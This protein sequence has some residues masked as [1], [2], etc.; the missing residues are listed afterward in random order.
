IRPALLAPLLERNALWL[1]D[2][3]LSN[4]NHRSAR[5]VEQAV[6]RPDAR[7]VRDLARVMASVTHDL[8]R[9]HLLDDVE[10]IT[11]PTLVIW[12]GR[13]RLLPMKPV[14]RW[15]R[16]LPAGEL[17]VLERCGHM[18]MIEDPEAVVR[19]MMAFLQVEE[20]K[21]AAGAR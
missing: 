8:T 15:V 21:A 19:R 10:P 1:L 7:F 11:Q 5:F 17:E 2:R 20:A 4:K 16:K 9:R 18:P 14:P 3:A 13:D 6:T 12:G